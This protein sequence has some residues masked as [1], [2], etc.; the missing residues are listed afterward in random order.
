M[1]QLKRLKRYVAVFFGVQPYVDST[2]PSSVGKAE[3]RV[4]GAHMYMHVLSHCI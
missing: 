2:K 1:K 4:R 3:K